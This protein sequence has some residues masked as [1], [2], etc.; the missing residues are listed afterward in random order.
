MKA[1]WLSGVDRNKIYVR[2]KRMTKRLVPIDPVTGDYTE[3]DRKRLERETRALLEYVRSYVDPQNDEFGIYKY[4]VPL[5]ESALDGTARLP[6]KFSDLPLQHASKEG[7]LPK[8]FD[9]L[10]SS[11]AITISG[12]ARELFD[13]VIINNVPHRYVN[14]ED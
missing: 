1:Y 9:A 10:Y 7:L 11:F 4:V 8:D 5:C 14:F 12:T 6:V 2:E 13:T 3:V